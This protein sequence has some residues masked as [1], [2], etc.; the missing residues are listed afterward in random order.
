MLAVENLSVRYFRDGAWFDA[1]REISFEIAPGETLALVGESGSGKS[2]VA[3]AL[4][5]LAPLGSGTVKFRGAPLARRGPRPVGMVFQDPLGS[6]DP[7]S[8]IGASIEEVLAVHGMASGPERRRRVA[9]LLEA[10]G[11][12]ETQAPARPRELSGG[13]QQRAAIA[14]GLAADPELLILDE[15]VS[16]LD[17]SVRAQILRLLAEL[18]SER[19]LA[20]L[21]IAHDL[22]VVR[23]LAMRVA[24]MY[25]GRLLELA[26][27]GEFF[28]RPLHPYSHE[29]LAAVP[30][31]RRT[32]SAAVAPQSIDV[33]EAACVFAHRCPY[34]DGP[35]FDVQPPLAAATPA[36]LVACHHWADLESART[37]A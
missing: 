13:Q 14:R 7:R 35:S 34:A 5:G 36:H 26:D 19:K 33:A 31:L 1:A 17:V 23:Q 15:P 32:V 30:S 20:Y 10:V 12:S 6:L 37:A 3:R 8:T 29:L 9:A 22:A 4:V 11:L 25:R 28:A 2:T 24:V 27:A 16:A 18:R 21:F